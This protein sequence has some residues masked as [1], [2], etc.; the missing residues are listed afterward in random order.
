MNFYL[1]FSFS[2]ALCCVILINKLCPCYYPQG[3]I[4]KIELLMKNTEPMPIV[5]SLIGQPYDEANFEKITNALVNVDN[6]EKVLK[7]CENG[8]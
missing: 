4:G 3:L 7:E 5:S 8:L 1:I 2:S 6:V